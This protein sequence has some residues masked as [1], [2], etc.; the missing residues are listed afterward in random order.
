[1]L[2]LGESNY[3][4]GLVTTLLDG[5]VDVKQ[6]NLLFC[7]GRVGAVQV[8]FDDSET[9]G[10]TVQLLTRL[11]GMGP[12]VPFGSHQPAFRYPL[13]GV[14]YDEMGR[15]S[16]LDGGSPVTVWDMGTREALYHPVAGRG[17]VSGQFW[18]TSRELARECAGAASQ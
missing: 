4:A 17:S 12:S 9:F 8:L 16:L 11:H 14:H 2:A 7:A 5:A 18:M 15:W 6:V 13:P 3:G 1:M 10:D